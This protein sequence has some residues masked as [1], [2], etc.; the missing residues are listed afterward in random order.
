[1]SASMITPAAVA[2][3]GGL[4]FEV[5]TAY[6]YAPGFG[7]FLFEVGTAYLYALFLFILWKERP[8]G[9]SKAAWGAIIVTTFWALPILL[10]LL[11][12]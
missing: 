5:R 4:L 12:Q 9:F 6:L 11:S 7:G 1:M 8:Q 10:I 2:G 3:F